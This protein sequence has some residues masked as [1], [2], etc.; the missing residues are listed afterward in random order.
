[1]RSPLYTPNF[2][3]R[4]REL[5]E[6]SAREI[7]PLLLSAIPAR[8][9]CDVGCG[10][11]TWLSE[12]MK[13]GVTDVTGLD[14]AYVP[15]SLLEIPEQN[16]LTVDLRDC[17]VCRVV[18]RR[19]DLALS[20]EVA[21]HLPRERA[22]DFVAELVSLAPV[23]AFSAA[24]PG[25]GGVGHINEQWQDYWAR[26]F[27]ERGYEVFDAIRPRIWARQNIAYWYK[28]NLLIYCASAY[29][30]RLSGLVVSS[31]P[32]QT[33]HPDAWL[34][35][36]HPNLKPL[37]REVWSAILSAVARRAP[38]VRP[39]S[40]ARV[41]PSAWHPEFDGRMTDSPIID[42]QPREDRELDAVEGGREAA[43]GDQRRADRRQR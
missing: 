9:V 37:L 12:F 14:G 10:T 8:S 25:Q 43:C 21:E 20:L 13:H 26:L 28:Q 31:G 6:S 36:C 4:G 32:L 1:M 40:P 17:E 24:I 27:R 34:Y 30:A 23:V 16:F 38:F 11:G 29:T 18:G 39:A 19:V 41:L 22:A 42:R 3:D 15:R 7:V 2:Y 33:V 35:Q 5:T